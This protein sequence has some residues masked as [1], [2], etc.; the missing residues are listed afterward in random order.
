MHFIFPVDGDM[1][2]KYDGEE[3]DGKLFIKVKAY[4]PACCKLMV[5]KVDMVYEDGCFTATLPLDGYRNTL[6]LYNASTL[7]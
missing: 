1:L 5:N 4:A 6:V 3:R 7:V 2:N